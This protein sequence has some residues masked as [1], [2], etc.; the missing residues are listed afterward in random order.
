MPMIAE[1][2]R[3]PHREKRMSA[4]HNTSQPRMGRHAIIMG[5][6]MAGLLAARVLADHFDAV[7]VLERDP[8]PAGNAPRKGVP[9]GQQPHALL[10]KGYE[11]LTG[12]FPDLPDALR[13]EDAVFVELGMD[14]RWYVSGD[15]RVRAK[16]TEPSPFMSRP[17]LERLVRERVMALPNVCILSGT[18]I[19]GLIADSASERI[20]GVRVQRNPDSTEVLVADLVIDAT[21]RGSRTPAWLEEL[22]YP[23]PEEDSIRINMGYTTRVYPRAP[24][25]LG[26]AK[27]FYVTP[28]A[29]HEKRFGAIFPI[30]GNRW[31]VCLGGWMG[32]HAPADEDGF[33]AFAR[34][35]PVPD[36]YHFLQMKEPLSEFRTFKYPFNLRRRYEKLARFPEGYLVLGDA[37]CSF[38][39]VY[40]Q[41]MSSA[42]LTIDALA[43][44]LRTRASGDLHG[45]ARQFFPKAAQRVDNPWR[46]AAGADFQYPEAEGTKEPGTD[47][48]NAYLARV[49]KATH[50]DPVVYRA[51]SRVLNL[52]DAPTS[53]MKPGILFRVL[54]AAFARPR[55]QP[56]PSV[57]W[58]SAG[59]VPQE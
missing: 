48:I 17:L 3:Q 23:R 15:F 45:L 55:P 26:D 29:P 10:A 43:E 27:A 20:V 44:C 56:E 30:E 31:L 9:Q 12:L 50:R 21:G 24:G 57:W 4:S 14:F 7:T 28:E 38:N 42:A 39:P 22:G 35:L 16:I 5:G 34:N 11:I 32:D 59:R 6:S 58:V 8:F 49:H 13:A 46:I 54:R 37:L 41:G 25:D 33:H 47:L 51:F 36:I 2:D 40:G 18:D 53:L 19:R 1:G 52:Q